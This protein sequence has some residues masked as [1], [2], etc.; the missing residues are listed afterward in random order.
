MILGVI[1]ARA[2]SK[3]IPH[4]NLYKLYDRPLIDYT[5]EAAA[6]SKIDDF[7]I[8]SDMDILNVLEMQSLVKRRYSLQDITLSHWQQ[9]P[10]SLARDST[11]SIDT[12]KHAVRRYEE[13]H[14]IKVSAVCLLQ[15][16]S[17]LRNKHDI[18]VAL[19]KYNKFK[20]S[21]YTGYNI[22]LKHKDKLHNKHDKPHFQRN[23]AIFISPRELLFEGCFWDKNS[24]EMEMPYIRSIDI[25]DMEDMAS[26]TILIKGGV[27]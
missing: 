18:N 9:R 5:I 3:R 20:R 21:L 22:I 23:G 19:D 8:S 4:K 7:I 2:G 24:I 1:P 16:T 27:L 6:Q 13:L 11:K 10:K 15:P 26:A 14:L 25:D 12:V 17:P